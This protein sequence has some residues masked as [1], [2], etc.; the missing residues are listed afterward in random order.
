MRL[1]SQELGRTLILSEVLD[2]IFN[3]LFEIFPRAER[4]FVLLKAPT[5]RRHSCRK[6]SG[7]ELG[8]SGAAGELK[9][10]K[11]VLNRVLNAGQ[12]ILSKDLS[13]EFPDAMAVSRTARFAP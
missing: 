9:I 13:Q 7:R 11:T 1:I 8:C 2:R 12:A 3:S 4:G 6:S 5:S 10:S